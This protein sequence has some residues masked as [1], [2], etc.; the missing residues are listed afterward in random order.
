MAPAGSVPFGTRSPGGSGSQD[1]SAGRF[2]ENDARC[3]FVVML[4]DCYMIVSY[5]MLYIYRERENFYVMSWTHVG[6]G[7]YLMIMRIRDWMG[8]VTL[9]T[10]SNPSI[11]PLIHGE[12]SLV[13]L[14]TKNPF[15]FTMLASRMGDST[16]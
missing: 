9:V 14:P 11:L 8:L 15:V 5:I 16:T 7:I 10:F 3:Y 2:A 4:Y 13:F 6:C 12:V 1:V